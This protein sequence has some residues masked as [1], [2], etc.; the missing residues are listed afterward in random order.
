[1]S[2][3]DEKTIK[4]ITASQGINKHVYSAGKNQ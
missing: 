2:L 3:Q 1:M 4:P